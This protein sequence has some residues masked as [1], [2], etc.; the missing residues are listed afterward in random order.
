MFK[1]TGN[2]VIV[3]LSTDALTQK[4]TT[5]ASGIITVD[6]NTT[7][8]EST[9]HVSVTS[10][11]EGRYDEKHGQWVPINLKVGDVVVISSGT[12]LQLDDKHRVV[13]VDDIFAKVE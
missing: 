1:A 12:G 6:S 8:N 3:D 5:H 10:V 9:H 7:K 11:G 4:M 13:N 2:R